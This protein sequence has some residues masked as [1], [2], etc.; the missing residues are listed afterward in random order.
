[1]V[2]AIYHELAIGIHLSPPSYTPSHL[3]H[4]SNP[5]GYHRASALV[6]LWKYTDFLFLYDLK[7]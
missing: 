4:H 1:M 7:N 2:F 6:A 5:S 3:P